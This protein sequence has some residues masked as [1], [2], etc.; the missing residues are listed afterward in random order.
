M[1]SEDYVLCHWKGDLW[2]A[3]VLSRA[4][5]QTHNEGRE[6]SLLDVQILSVEKVQ[7][8]STDVR[9]LTEAGTEAIVSSAG[10]CLRAN[11]FPGDALYRDSG[12][13][14]QA[15]AH[16]EALK[17][18]LEILSS[19]KLAG[20]GTPVES[21]QSEPEAPRAQPG[22]GPCTDKKQP[23]RKLNSE[24]NLGKRACLPSHHMCHAGSEHAL[25]DEQS[26]AHTATAASAHEMQAQVSE[27]SSVSSLVPTVKGA[28]NPS[29]SE[30]TLGAPAPKSSGHPSSWK[31]RYAKAQ[32]PGLYMQPV[33]VLSRLK[34]QSQKGEDAG[35]GIKVCDPHRFT[36][37]PKGMEDSA[38][39]ASQAGLPGAG[40]SSVSPNSWIPH[41]VS[42]ANRKRKCQPAGVN[43]GAKKC[44]V[45]K[46]SNEPKVTG[47]K[48][49]SE[50][51]KETQSKSVAPRSKAPLIET[52]ML[53]WFYLRG[54]PFWPSVVQSVDQTK[55][56]AR[57][58]LIEPNLLSE[59]RGI[60]VPLCKLKPLECRSKDLLVQR[61][62]QHYGL[63]VAWCL[64]LITHYQEVVASGNFKGSFLDYLSSNGHFLVAETFEETEQKVH[65]P[66]VKYP[67]Q[68]D[69]EEKT[70]QDGKKKDEIMEQKE[71]EEDREMAEM[72]E[73][74]MDKTEKRKEENMEEKQGE[75]LR[76]RM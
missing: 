7:V 18:A 47:T 4:G 62:S 64:S 17:V 24:P 52:G 16:T 63:G 71:L 1:E 55:N 13:P 11:E 28:I 50:K 12:P 73:V 58:L 43:T 9:P 30:K 56:S 14:G 31:C 49:A 46:T 54:Y 5:T 76:G 6:G 27:S 67:N 3:K 42:T 44:K 34:D 70:F 33:V 39:S 51:R 37:S 38:K 66:V 57:V 61:A 45:P 26:V 59:Q 68:G 10:L 35:E 48:K 23:K 74:K 19:R 60:Q 41:A 25:P 75:E 2:P 32:F 40:A 53:V 15:S 20:Q 69:S 8:R 65:F 22:P 21:P 29:Q 72:V 36:I